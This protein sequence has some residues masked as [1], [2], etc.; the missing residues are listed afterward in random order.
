V[1]RSQHN[2]GGDYGASE[3]WR[4]ILGDTSE[5]QHVN[6]QHFSGAARSF[7]IVAAI[8]PQTEV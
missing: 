1:Q 2:D 8:V 5:A 3:L 7:E 6:M 4:D